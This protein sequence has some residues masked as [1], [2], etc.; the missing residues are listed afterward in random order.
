MQTESK[1]LKLT[2]A[3][4]ISIGCDEVYEPTGFVVDEEARELIHFDTYEFLRMLDDDALRRFSAICAKGSITSLLDLMRFMRQN[5]EHAEGERCELA[6]EFMHHYRQV[7][8]MNN[9][10]RF[11]Q[12]NLNRFQISRTAFN[13]HTNLPVIPGSSIKGAIRTAVLNLRQK[14]HPVARQRYE[15]MNAFQ[16]NKA[17]R[18]LQKQV[19]GGSFDTDPFRL[20]KVSDFVPAGGFKRRV[21]YAANLKKRPSERDSQ[22][23]PQILE[24][25]EPGAV[26]LGTITIQQPDNHRSHIKNPLTWQ[27]I[28]QALQQFYGSEN[29]RENRE[30][31]GI[32]GQ[33]VQL[34]SQ[35]LPLRIGRHSG[36]ECVTV[37]GHR[38]IKVSPPGKKPF[39]FKDHATTLWLA[40]ESRKP[41]SGTHLRPFGWAVFHTLTTEALV[42]L[43]QS[44]HDLEQEQIQKIRYRAEQHRTEAEQ[45]ARRAAVKEAEEKKKAEEAKRK[46]EEDARRQAEDKARMEA[47]LADLPEDA[48]W[49]VRH[50]R[51][52]NWQQDNSALLTDMETFFDSFASPDR[53]ALNT[54]AD[55]LNRKWAGI[56]D[57]PDA[58]KGKKKKPKFKDRPRNLALKIIAL[59]Q[60]DK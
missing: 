4:P 6:A 22:G 5:R 51:E 47:E 25:I 9:N 7:L 39:R 46:A 16:A 19:L 40:A 43:K 14:N 31:S 37:A 21:I 57:N 35:G 30:L 1:Y 60:G 28:Q 41:G 34:D 44:A 29:R 55:W 49:L 45:L 33:P 42:H 12:Q 36:A 20:V 24:V 3:S 11:I 48:A 54:A 32:N 27:E 50:A 15:D 18:T 8:G 56:M 23:P 2:V 10:P 59:Q 38:S 52:N 53:Q 58:T 13:P 17:N 26:F